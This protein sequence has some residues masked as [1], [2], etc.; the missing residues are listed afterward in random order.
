[1]TIA[2]DDLLPADA[3]GDG[4]YRVE[5]SAENPNAPASDDAN[6]DNLMDE[7]LAVRRRW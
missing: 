4:A 5:L 2:L 7:V 3:R 1:M 6:A